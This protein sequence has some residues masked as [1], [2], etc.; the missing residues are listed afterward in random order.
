MANTFISFSSTTGA[1]IGNNEFYI[2]A[3]G[4]THYTTSTSVVVTGSSFADATVLGNLIATQVDGVAG[5]D[6]EFFELVVGQTGTLSGDRYGVNIS[7]NS[8]DTVIANSG[9]IT[10]NVG[11]KAFTNSMEIQNTGTILGTE[12]EAVEISGLNPFLSNTGTITGKTSGVV[13]FVDDINIQNSG[14]ITGG[15]NAILG[16]AGLRLTNSGTISS[17]GA[18]AININ[19]SLGVVQNSGLIEGTVN[20]AMS[21]SVLGFYD[22]RLG[23]TR[24]DILG[25]NVAAD[26]L[27]GGDHV[28][29]LF[30][31]GGDDT[32]HGGGGDDL[33]YG[34]AGD[35]MIVGGD[36]DDTLTSGGGLDVVLGG[37][38]DDMIIT[39]RV[40]QRIEGG[41]GNDTVL[42]ETGGPQFMINLAS[43]VFSGT[44][45]MFGIENIEFTSGRVTDLRATNGDNRITVDDATSIR[46]Y[47]GNDSVI[48]QDDAQFV[49]TGSGADYVK[50]GVKVVNLNTGSDDDY[51]EGGSG[52]DTVF[53]GTGDD[54]VFGNDGDDTLRGNDGIDTLNGGAGNDNVLGQGG[55][56]FVAGH[57]GDDFVSGG[58]G[59]DRLFGGAGNDSLNGGA[60]ADDLFAQSGDNRMT[61]G[62]GADIFYVQ[63]FNETLRIL[64]FEDGVDR[65]WMRN[66]NFA[67]EADALSNFFQQGNNVR[68]ADDNNTLVVISNF[69]LADL[70]AA[71][72]LL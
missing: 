58:A 7:G 5:S 18:I 1:A 69:D 57:D 53:L 4:A 14:T 61:G 63:S 52:A 46:T 39:D 70:S 59:D 12:E 65:L 16:N 32:I 55:D 22:G 31:R 68:F 28:D 25:T 50:I 56:D 24:G 36:G 10:G 40:F 9:V 42:I 67:D 38:G 23:E 26:T 43:G 51:V 27:L 3:E 60:G 17:A 49:S 21:N 13:A 64:D 48:I 47:G 8:T 45:G 72:L 19:G 15:T 37:T 44:D 62:T 71:D 34:G 20:F 66:Y 33:L 30:G 54:F 6:V 35:D 11:V 2:L 41:S 29:R